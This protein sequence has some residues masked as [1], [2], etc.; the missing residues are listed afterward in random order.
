LLTTIFV[1][2]Y[3]FRVGLK[4]AKSLLATGADTD[5]LETIIKLLTYNKEELIMPDHETA[6]NAG[7]V[8]MCPAGTERATESM[9][10]CGDAPLAPAE[11][12]T[13][14]AA[15]RTDEELLTDARVRLKWLRA[16]TEFDK[17]DL[18]R[19]FLAKEVVNEVASMLRVYAGTPEEGE[20]L[21][22]RYLC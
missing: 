6:G 14:K 7:P 18:T 1:Y 17:F 20:S 2:R 10:V 8:F 22:A 19:R 13:T 5:L 9:E 4:R 21:A 15:D 16:I 3:L 11:S 12:A